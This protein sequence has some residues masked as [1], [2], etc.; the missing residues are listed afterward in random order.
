[1]LFYKNCIDTSVQRNVGYGIGAYKVRARQPITMFV[2]GLS[3]SFYVLAL[4]VEE[5]K[6]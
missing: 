4:V 1:M 3:T 6:W 5:M 2:I